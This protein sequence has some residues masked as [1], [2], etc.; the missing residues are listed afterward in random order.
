M[1]SSGQGFADMKK[2]KAFHEYH[3]IKRKA[4]QEGGNRTEQIYKQEFG[5]EGVYKDK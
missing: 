3:K 5:G 1:C 4:Q 2:K